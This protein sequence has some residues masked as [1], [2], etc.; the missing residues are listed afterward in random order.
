VDKHL[1]HFDL[2]AAL[3]T[4]ACAVSD[5]V[6]QAAARH[7]RFLFHDG[8][9]DSGV[10]HVQRGLAQSRPEVRHFLSAQ[11]ATT[12]SRLARAPSAFVRKSDFNPSQEPMAGERN[13]WLRALGKVMGYASCADW[14]RA[15]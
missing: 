10:R 12:L 11:E 4:N 7:L 9:N 5:L 15:L 2:W 13:S 3:Q 6:A 14:R 1:I 8:V